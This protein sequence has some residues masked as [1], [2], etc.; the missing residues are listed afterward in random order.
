VSDSMHVYF[1]V[2]VCARVCMSNSLHVF[3]CV[4]L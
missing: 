4:S 3:V 1:I 2:Y